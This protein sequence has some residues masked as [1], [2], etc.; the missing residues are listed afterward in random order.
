MPDSK[1]DKS[2]KFIKHLLLNNSKT[3][4]V[5]P[6]IHIHTTPTGQAAPC[7]VSKSCADNVGIGNS[8]KHSLL[9]LVNSDKMNQLRLD[10]LSGNKNKECETCYKQDEAGHHSFR[11]NS[12]EEYTRKGMRGTAI[13]KESLIDHIIDTTDLNTGK[14]KEFKM[15]YFDIRFSNICNFKCRT[16]GSAFSSQWEKEDLD[17]KAKVGLPMYAEPIPKGNRKEFLTEILEQVPN[18]EVAYFAGGEPLITHEH[19]VLLEEMI[20]TKNTKIL[21]KYNTNLSNFKY[22]KKNVFNLWKHFDNTVQLYASLDHF[23]PKAE[24]IRHGTEWPDIEKNFSIA[25]KAKNITI[26]INTVFSVLN[27]LSISHFYKYIADN[28][29]ILPDTK[30][31]NGSTFSLYCMMGPEHLSVH[32]LPKEYKLQVLQQLRIAIDY[33]E[34][35][36]FSKRQ[37]KPL[38]EAIEFTLLHDTWEEQKSKFKEEIKRIDS[39]REEDFMTT[40]PELAG[41]IK[42]PVALKP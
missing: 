5:M 26:E 20:K 8:N 33:L 16:C 21:L 1:P 30:K 35:L 3:F 32:I 31:N 18:F 4:C 6:W 14:I 13:R 42:P 34:E 25:Q 15:R 40:F 12:I 29:W 38:Y 19:Y 7:C 39:M 11:T 23:G 37:T 10:M 28:H 24:Y 22:K 17:S 27:A 36:K 41:L 2:N 9:E